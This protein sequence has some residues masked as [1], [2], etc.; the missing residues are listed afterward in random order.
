MKPQYGAVV[1]TVA[2]CLSCK[3]PASPEELL[4]ALNTVSFDQAVI[5]DFPRY[6]TLFEFLHAHVDTLI[7]ARDARHFV[8]YVNGS[9]DGK[10]D[11]TYATP[12]ECYV[13]FEHNDQYDLN[14]APV[15]IRD[16]L[17][18]LFHQFSATQIQSF[19]VCEE[20]RVVI[21]IRQDNPTETLEA[22]HELIWDPRLKEDRPRSSTYVLDKDTILS[23]DCIYRI[24]LVEDL[25]G[26]SR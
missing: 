23:P 24:G 11:T 20:G 16:E 9:R 13:F 18:H 25:G 4:A 21:I 14:T 2:F 15:F 22:M 26:S 17:H 5:A 3:P 8:T 7:A 12:E 19:E 1:G 6:R 10:R